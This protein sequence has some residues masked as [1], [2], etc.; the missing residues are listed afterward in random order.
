MEKHWLGAEHGSGASKRVFDEKT[1]SAAWPLL[2][3]LE[4]VDRADPAR[5]QY[6]QIVVMGAARHRSVSQA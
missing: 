2:R 3:T 1:K 5:D 6:D 4:V